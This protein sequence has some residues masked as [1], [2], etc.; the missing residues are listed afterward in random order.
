MPY[1]AI[2]D[3]LVAPSVGGTHGRVLLE[4]QASGLPVV[5]GDTPGVRDVVRDGITGR[6]CPAGNAESLSQSVALLLRQRSFLDA[7]AAASTQVIARDH[8]IVSAAARLN[9]IVTGLI[10]A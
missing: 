1:Y 8:H 2:S 10:S 3:L 6:L 7:Y 9:E 4:A 5:A